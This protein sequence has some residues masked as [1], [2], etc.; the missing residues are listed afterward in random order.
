MIISIELTDEDWGHVC[1][2]LDIA[3]D[4][5]DAYVEQMD[6]LDGPDADEMD[7]QVRD[8]AESR[9]IAAFITTLVAHAYERARPKF[10][11]N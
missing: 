1:G 3:A 10:S 9:R 6:A 5:S 2:A 8:A 11:E 4:D 7:A